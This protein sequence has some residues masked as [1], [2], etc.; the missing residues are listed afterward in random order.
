MNWYKKSQN[1]YCYELSCVDLKDGMPI[2]EMINRSVDIS[3]EEFNKYV[4]IE[5]LSMLFGN[6][7]NFDKADNSG[8]R[9]Q[10][11]YHVSFHK[12][13]YEGTSCYYLDHS[14][15]EYIFLPCG[16]LYD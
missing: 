16:G 3:W 1:Q 13:Y 4:S 15:I 2:Q 7:Y 10:D 5:Q 14:S 8:L 12:S 6:I 11:D 9:I